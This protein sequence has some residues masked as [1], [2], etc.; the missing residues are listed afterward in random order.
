MR[1]D[2]TR[3]TLFGE[4]NKFDIYDHLSGEHEEILIPKATSGHGGGDFGV[5]AAFIKALQGESEAL[6]TA[7]ESL[8]SHLMAFAA[9]ESR[10][11]K[12]SH[13]YEGLSSGGRR[14]GPQKIC[15]M[16]SQAGNPYYL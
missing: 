4:G 16:T 9:E 3:A 5:V 15:I 11:Q 14:G 10:L 2:G 6:T 8:E 1:Y 13:R 7:R 12:Q